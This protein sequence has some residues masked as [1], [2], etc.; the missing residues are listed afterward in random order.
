MDIRNALK[1]H[2]LAEQLEDLIG[3]EPEPQVRL[4]ASALLSFASCHTGLLRRLCI[5][6]LALPPR[7]KV[8]LFYISPSALLL[9]THMLHL[10]AFGWGPF[11]FGPCPPFSPP[12][13]CPDTHPRPF[14][15]P[16]CCS[17]SPR[18]PAAAAQRGR[19]PRG[20]QPWGPSQER[21]RRRHDRTLK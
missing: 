13:P 1:G 12:P 17:S 16:F 21:R 20:S 18:R 8:V 6:A 19:P 4:Q 2:P 5:S 9:W 14:A 3:P 10:L 15:L 7:H 11:A